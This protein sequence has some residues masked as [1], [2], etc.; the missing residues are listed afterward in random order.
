M[1]QRTITARCVVDGAAAAAV[2]GVAG[3]GGVTGAQDGVGPVVNDAAADEGCVIG[4]DGGTV[5]GEEAFVENAAAIADGGVGE[6]GAVGQGQG[7]LVVDGAA[8]AG[9]G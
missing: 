2:R 5:E 1:K 9:A 6:H 4:G 3:E 8:E 7:A